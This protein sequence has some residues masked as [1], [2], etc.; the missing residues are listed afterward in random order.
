MGNHQLGSGLS[1]MT[2]RLLLVFMIFLAY[3]SSSAQWSRPNRPI[4]PTPPSQVPRLTP[5]DNW[6]GE[7][8]AWHLDHLEEDEFAAAWEPDYIPPL[9][10]PTIPVHY[11]CVLRLLNWEP[12]LDA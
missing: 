6:T 8:P 5:E 2:F 11:N 7:G 12:Y 10:S 1:K 3:A 4:R 9:M